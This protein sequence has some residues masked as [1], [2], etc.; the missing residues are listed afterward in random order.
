MPLS[1][2]DQRELL[3]NRDVV[4]R[5]YKRADGLYDVEGHITDTKTYDFDSRFRGA[6]KAGVPVHEMWIR[7]TFDETLTIKAVEAVTDYSPFPNSCPAITPNYQK[8]VG[9]RIGHGWTKAIKER[10][11]GVEGCTHL[12]ELLSPV[13][14][15]AI[16]TLALMRR[17]PK[18]G[19]PPVFMNSCHGWR[20]DGEAI[21]VI[22]P[23]FYTGEQK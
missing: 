2:P 8:I 15:T 11:G 13:A 9:L 21:K 16:Q 1:E 6:V 17:E 10:L 5:G 23:E 7:L 3:H 18:P 20:S 4:C 14:T 22:A 12:V 19:Q